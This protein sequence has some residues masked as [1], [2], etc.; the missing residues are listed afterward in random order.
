MDE[1]KFNLGTNFM[2]NIVSKLLAKAIRKKLGYDVSIL[3]NSVNVSYNNDGKIKLH[4]DADG[5]MNSVE[6]LKLMKDI[7]ID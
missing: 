4:V 2:R 7:G 3:I 1:L 5:E 6:F